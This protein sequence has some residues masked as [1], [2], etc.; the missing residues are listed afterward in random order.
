VARR[1]TRSLR[2]PNSIICGRLEPASCFLRRPSPCAGHDWADTHPNVT[3]WCLSATGW[4]T[5]APWASLAAKNRPRSMALCHPPWNILTLSSVGSSSVDPR[6]I[7]P[8]A[9]PDLSGCL[10]RLAGCPGDRL[11]S[12][13]EVARRGCPG[14]PPTVHARRNTARAA[15]ILSLLR[16][17]S[18]DTRAG[19][20]LPPL[21]AL[22]THQRVPHRVHNSSEAG[23]LRAP[24]QSAPGAGASPAFAPVVAETGTH[25]AHSGPGRG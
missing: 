18:K 21:D 3:L 16:P 7:L 22:V 17:L 13:V 19:T 24:L 10:Q 6:T 14:H 9:S 2:R 1:A 12:W 8:D 23:T 5:T 25:N 4:G 11:G 20:G 15:Y